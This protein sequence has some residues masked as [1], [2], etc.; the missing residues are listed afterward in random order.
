M[1]P[2]LRKLAVG[3]G[4]GACA[5][6]LVLAVAA[7]SDLPARYE[8][9]TYDWRMRLAEDPQA[10]DKNIVLVEINDL[11]IRQLQ[12]GYNMRWPWPRVAFG[13]A[14]DFLHR[15]GAKVIAI[16]VSF[17]ERDKVVTYVFD[18]PNDK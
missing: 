5:A 12:A 7:V 3:V 9:T 8:L 2:V 13:L 18:D 15:G 4:L 17:P 10:I 14:V 6:G 16:D 1:Q 11:T